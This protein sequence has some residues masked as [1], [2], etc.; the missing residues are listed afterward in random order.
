MREEQLLQVI[1]LAL[2]RKPLGRLDGSEMRYLR[3][4]CGLT[5]QA[6][7]DKLNV[8]RATVVDRERGNSDMGSDSE[9]V[10]RALILETFWGLMQDKTTCHLEAHHIADLENLRGLF[11]RL[12]LQKPGR[13]RKTTRISQRG[14]RWCV[15][16]AA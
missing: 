4:I 6:L 7:A 15:A 9:F 10:F 2:L 14:G 5:Q 1:A 8:R 16:E 13:P 11:L 3:K 12:P